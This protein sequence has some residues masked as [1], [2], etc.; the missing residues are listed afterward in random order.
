MKDAVQ[1]LNENTTI[2]KREKRTED[3]TIRKLLIHL[4]RLVQSQRYSEAE[5]IADNAFTQNLKHAD[6]YYIAGE[7]KRALAIQ[8]STC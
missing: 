5:K 6:L 7:I 3:E 1:Q 2:E 8:K 4:K